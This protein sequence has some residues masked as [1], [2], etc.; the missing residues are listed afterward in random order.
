MWFRLFALLVISSYASSSIEAALDADD[1][2]TSPPCALNALQKKSEMTK[3][4]DNSA[5]NRSLSG[6]GPVHCICK[7]HEDKYYCAKSFAGFT[8]CYQPCP[9][10]CTRTG[11]RQFMCGGKHENMWLDRYFKEQEEKSMT[12]KLDPK[13]KK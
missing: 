13:E 10:L 4:G 9:E 6:D 11:G 5:Q 3:D 7:D 1:E 12:C 2:C 8:K